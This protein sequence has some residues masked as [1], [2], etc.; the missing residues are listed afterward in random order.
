MTPFILNPQNN[1]SQLVWVCSVEWITGSQG[2]LSRKLIAAKDSHGRP[3]RHESVGWIFVSRLYRWQA[4]QLQAKSWGS[5][6]A[7]CS[8]GQEPHGSAI[9]SCCHFN[10]FA[11]KHREHRYGCTHRC[12]F[13]VYRWALN[14]AQPNTPR[15]LLHLCYWLH[16]WFFPFFNLESHRAHFYPGFLFWSFSLAAGSTFICNALHFWLWQSLL[17]SYK[18]T[19]QPVMKPVRASF[20]SSLGYEEL[21]LLIMFYECHNTKQCK[22]V[23]RVRFGTLY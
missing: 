19:C 2:L 15:L 9:L 21:F 8:D 6:P 14:E 7:A 17:E 16:V 12:V 5:D 3:Q 23:S 13:F 10:V 22:L 20:L 11:N 1:K 4:T 18:G